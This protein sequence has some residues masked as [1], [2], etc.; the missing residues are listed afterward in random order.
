MAADE[1]RTLQKMVLIAICIGIIMMVFFLYYDQE[2]YSAIALT[3]D[4]IIHNTTDN[5]VS[6]T[7]SVKCLEKGKTEYSLDFFCGDTQITTKQ[8]TLKRGDTLEERTKLELPA[9]TSL[10]VKISLLLKTGTESDEVHFW[11]KD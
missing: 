9:N 10:P 7:Y 1:D 11:V 6:F 3:P 4:S 8:F 2:N 5:S